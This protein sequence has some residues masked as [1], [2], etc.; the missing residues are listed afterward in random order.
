LPDLFP[1]Y[2]TAI[3]SY[4]HEVI[5]SP[6]HPVMIRSTIMLTPCTTMT[7]YQAQTV[8]RAISIITH[9][10]REEPELCATSPK[11]TVDYIRL[12]FYG[13]HEREHFLV[14][15]LD[16]RNKL[17]S[18]EFLFSGTVDHVDI[19]PR[20]IAQTA[21]KLNAHAIILA[22]NHPAGTMEPSAAD[23]LITE[24]INKVMQLLDIRLLDHII[25]PADGAA[26]YSFAE[27]GKI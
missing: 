16:T 20:V 3:F 14:L 5:F 25:I 9:Q 12:K 19:H 21:L 4:F 10:L 13:R 24:H 18:S 11:V 2:T 1:G 27:R 6:V 17:I 26:Y 7:P 22:H 23:L 15:F 8:R